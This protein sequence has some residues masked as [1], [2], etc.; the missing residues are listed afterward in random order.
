MEANIM[1]AKVLDAWEAARDRVAKHTAMESEARAAGVPRQSLKSS[2]L[3]LRALF[4]ERHG[5]LKEKFCPARAFIDWRLEQVEEG[6]LKTEKLQEVISVLD[7][8]DDTS[9]G[10][11]DLKK[12][13]T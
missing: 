5:E 6:E 8:D 10:L 12:D 9:A 2:H 1:I 4:K 3:S 11:L 7:E 13:G